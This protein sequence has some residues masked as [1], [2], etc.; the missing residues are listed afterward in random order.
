MILNERQKIVGMLEECH[1]DLTHIQGSMV[2]LKSL[3]NESLL[4]VHLFKAISNEVE[5]WL[6][7]QNNNSVVTLA[8]RNVFELY[9][10]MLEVNSN[11]E[12]L[13][14]F[15]A[16]LV[17][18]RDDL[19][20][21]FMNKCKAAGHPIPERALSVL[22]EETATIPFENVTTRPFNMRN[23]AKEH[24]YIEDYDF[25]Y[26]LSSKLIHPSALKVF[27]IENNSPQYQV[28]AMAGYYFVSK[29]TDY[30]V[31]LYNDQL[32]LQVANT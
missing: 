19:S 21:A 27:G 12:S 8:S 32:V 23:L 25:F 20:A 15:Y 1:R 18:D 30:A 14:R 3:T 31:S 26:K 4:N 28:V 22:Q 29:A 6:R 17:G 7:N 9:L 24:N 10:I 13:K 5:L 11:E 16:Q 2:D